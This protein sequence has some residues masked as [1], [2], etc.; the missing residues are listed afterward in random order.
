MAVDLKIAYIYIYAHARF[1]D[2][3][4]NALQMFGKTIITLYSS[5]HFLP[6]SD[7]CGPLVVVYDSLATCTHSRLLDKHALSWFETTKQNNFTCWCG[8]KFK[9]TPWT[10]SG[11]VQLSQAT[12]TNGR[13]LDKYFSL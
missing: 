1:N 8:R 12:S 5:S 6:I 4:F 9:T 11:H 13:L 10:L 3:D 2:R 7:D